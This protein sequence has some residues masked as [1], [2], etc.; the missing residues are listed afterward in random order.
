M[1][2]K[3]LPVLIPLLVACSGT[4]RKQATDTSTGPS[5]QKEDVAADQTKADVVGPL[6]VLDLETDQYL[7]LSTDAGFDLDAIEL[8]DSE[9][10]SNDI[11]P[12]EDT[13]PAECNFD[14]LELTQD[15]PKMYEFYELCIPDNLPAI[16]DQLKLIDPT[17]YCGVAG[18]F[19][20][21]TVGETGCHGDL[22]F[23]QGTK[24]ITDQ[25]WHQ[26]CQLSLITL[27]STIGG[28]HFIY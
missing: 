18:G 26:L 6:D 21:C 16:E 9:D 4:G 17:L 28:G 14:K 10:T 15:N 13:Q 3:L 19:A 25:K 7:D 8:T 2:N 12:D 1:T 22:K 23:E 24:K 20:G 5:G 11:A 27:V